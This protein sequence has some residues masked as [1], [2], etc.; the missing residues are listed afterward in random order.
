MDAVDT[1][2]VNIFNSHLGSQMRNNQAKCIPV[3]YLL[4]KSIVFLIMFTI[5]AMI[6]PTLG[7]LCR[8][9]VNSRPK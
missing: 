6:E 9:R 1:F 2:M 7:V 4:P 5:P 3:A 8:D